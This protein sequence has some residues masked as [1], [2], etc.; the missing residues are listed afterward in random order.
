MVARRGGSHERMKTGPQN[1]QDNGQSVDAL[2]CEVIRHP[3]LPNAKLMNRWRLQVILRCTVRGIFE[4]QDRHTRK[5]RMQIQFR[6]A[7]AQ[8]IGVVLLIPS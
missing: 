4:A 6:E 8:T 3:R 1:R 5:G 2:V 7:V